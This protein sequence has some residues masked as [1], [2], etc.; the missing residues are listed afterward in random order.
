[1]QPKIWPFI[2]VGFAVPM[3]SGCTGTF[4]SCTT[5]FG[6]PRQFQTVDIPDAVTTTLTGINNSGEIVGY[7]ADSQGITRAVRGGPA[8]F[9]PV[10]PPPLPGGSVASSSE[11]LA[12]NSRGSIIIMGHYPAGAQSY[13]FDGTSFNALSF[14]VTGSLWITR[15]ASTM[16]LGW[17]APTTHRWVG[18]I[19]F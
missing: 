7:S 13:L 19:F 15:E 17:L 12:I 11:A 3:I 16:I 4:V 10:D 5:F 9:A 14:P 8:N 18:E 6:P 2:I 1:M